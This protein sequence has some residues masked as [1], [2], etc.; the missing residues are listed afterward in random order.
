MRPTKIGLCWAQKG[1]LLG[2]PPTSGNAGGL[3]QTTPFTINACMDDVLEHQPIYL[4]VAVKR[5]GSNINP[6]VQLAQWSTWSRLNEVRIGAQG[7]HF[8]LPA[9]SVENH[10]W[11]L[12]FHS[13]DAEK[14]WV[15]RRPMRGLNHEHMRGKANVNSTSMDPSTW[16][17]ANGFTECCKSCTA[18]RCLQTGR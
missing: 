16:A 1:L 3:T 10:E 11:K 15:V 12:Y 8:V 13:Y 14:R 4:T 7:K 6:T 9:I 18:C 5:A 2:P 17:A